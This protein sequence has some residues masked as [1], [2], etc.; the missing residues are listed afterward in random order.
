MN[1][2]TLRQL[3]VVATLAVTIVLNGLANALPL[4]GQTTGEISD[5]FPIFFVP[6]GY[7][8]AIWG[9]IYLGL[10]G[11]AAFQA[12]PGQRENPRLRQIGYLFA[13][14]N[15]VNAAWVVAW[16]Y[17]LFPLTLVLIVT[18]LLALIAI[19]LR[20][21]VGRPAVSTV[22][23]LLVRLP[24]SIYLGWVSVATIA[25]ASQVL[26]WLGWQGAPLSGQAWAAIMLAVATALGGAM[27]W[28]RRD[29]GYLLVF[30][31]AFVGIGVKH[32]SEPLV[33]TS[34]Y[35]AAGAIA[36]MVVAAAVF[37]RRPL[38]PLAA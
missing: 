21:R 5:R 22:E 28:T 9:L 24:F 6:A 3:V 34:A 2:D 15:L 10:L 12:L 23:S 11:V 1:R 25:N 37:R 18:L 4:N 14:T 32:A 29:I 8:F 27:A 20:L 7:V 36:L 17:E 33:A 35:F 19:Y 30:V 38:R 13:F 26:Y 16:H 31:W